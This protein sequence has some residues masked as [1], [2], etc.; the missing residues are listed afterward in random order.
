M[1]V[2]AIDIGGTFTDL[3]GFDEAKGAFVQA[4]SLTTPAHLVQGIID[5]LNKSGLQAAAIDELMH[6]STI[7][8]NTLIERKGA[9]T[10]LIVTRGT[11]DV[12]AIGR[13]NRPEAYNLLFHKHR[14]LVPRRL[15]LEADE[16][17]L[18]SGDIHA[19]LRRASVEEACRALADEGVE[20]VAVCFL[21]SYSNPEHEE[22]AGEIVRALLPDAYLS[23][24]HEIL[25]EYR[26]FERI[27]TTVVNAY[28]GPKVG[29]YVRSLK[30][31]LGAIGFRGD[32][33]IM[34]S[35]GGVMTPELAT[36]CPVAMMESG[37]V[38]GIIASAQVGAALGF[39]NVISFDM[40]G[41]TAKSSLIRDGEA[42]LA[43]GYYVGGYA[44][45]HPVMLPMIDV[46]EVGAGGGSIA[47]IDEI[48]ALKVGPQS[49]GADPGPICYR[50]GGSE[51]TITDANVVLGRLDPDGFLGGQM[52]LDAEGA[53]RGIAEKIGAPLKME[54]V[55]AAQAIV[56]IA[57][58]KMSLA[59]REVS[60]A[61]GY[62][63]RD[64]A[65]VAS[66]GAGPLHVIA[67]ARELH[68]PTVI[69]PLFPSHFSALGML[70]ADERHDFTRTH[71]ADL[72]AIDFAEL[73]GVYEE[74]RR[75]AQA[76]LRHTR[77]AQEQIALDLRYVGQ[78]FTLSVPIT[79]K[80]LQAGDRKAVRKAFDALYEH[81]YAHHSADE[82]VEMVNM[83]LGI[84][85][86]RAKLKFPRL[87]KAKGPAAAA[88]HRNVYFADAQKPVRCP[89]YQ[90]DALKAGARI[91][92]P[93]LIQEH[94]TTTVLF[95]NDDCTVMPSG[96]LIIKVGGA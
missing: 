75:Q 8:I 12:Y 31:S 50:G 37:P 39:Q 10:G 28:I 53:A 42:T 43:P 66:G 14:P 11:R 58:A 94:G 56:E 15:T 82:P 90:R 51:P 2:V 38:G 49:A 77:N 71:F 22:T 17:M 92:G 62:D 95:K 18:A 84:V 69:V 25:R 60:V 85:G 59:V 63:P 88:A 74:M 19:P 72:A 57:I 67:I 65:L 29:G 27:S 79:L 7:A 44:G 93:A 83:R 24:S 23:L 5:C 40:G 55:A 41:T 80:Q 9:A 33:S 52:K 46:V 96:E 16:R 48:G 30:S 61:K 6:G 21:H 35:N 76:S 26:E 45:G 70:L 54:T 36:Q 4:K 89:L 34:R 87:G 3:I 91:V 32:L 78:E 47:W 81:R 86:K 13:G 64:F 20:S 73:V 68:I 1:L